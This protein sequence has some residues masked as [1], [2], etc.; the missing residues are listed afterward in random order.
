MTIRNGSRTMFQSLV[1][2]VLFWLGNHVALAQ[3]LPTV[4]QPIA[5]SMDWANGANGP[6]V[7]ALRFDE[8]AA[9]S[10]SLDDLPKNTDN[11]SR[12]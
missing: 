9:T 6:V 7:P 2:L 10:A 5:A 1:G 3:S 8:P 4:S 12:S 11:G